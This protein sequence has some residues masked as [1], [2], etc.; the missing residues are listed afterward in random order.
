MPIANIVAPTNSAGSRA[1]LAYRAIRD[2]ILS[3]RLALGEPLR[4]E[5]I[6]QHLGMSRTP[7]REA[8]NRLHA[9]GLIEPAEPR[10]Y[11]VSTVSAADVFHVYTVREELEALS[12]R[13]AARRITPHQLFQLSVIV[14]SMEAALGDARRSSDLNREFHEIIYAAAGNPVLKQIM[15]DLTGMVARFPVSAY[16][17]EGRARAA[18]EEHRAIL[19]ALARHDPETAAEAGRLHLHNGQSARLRALREHARNGHPEAGPPELQLL[20]LSG[21]ADVP[22]LGAS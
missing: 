3:S 9:D 14:D 6:A 10:G 5:A 19:D 21:A 20:P 7:V 8:L 16:A 13:L 2:A 15:D 18:V 12:M 17:V 4:E 22:A 11:V 1:E